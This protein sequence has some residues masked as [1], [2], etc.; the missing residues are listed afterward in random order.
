MCR[1]F[2]DITREQLIERAEHLKKT[3]RHGWRGQ[4]HK[5][6]YV[7]ELKVELQRIAHKIACMDCYKAYTTLDVPMWPKH[8]AVPVIFS[9][10]K[11]LTGQQ[12]EQRIEKL[13]GLKAPGMVKPCTKS[14][15]ANVSAQ[16]EY[17]HPRKDT[18]S[19]IRRREKQLRETA[20]SK[21]RE[22]EE[23][24]KRCKRLLAEHQEKIWSPV[25]AIVQEAILRSSYW[26]QITP[27]KF[28]DNYW[29]TFS[30]RVDSAGGLRSFYLTESNDGLSLLDIMGRVLV[31]SRTTKDIVSYVSQLLA[32]ADKHRN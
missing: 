7:Y 3:I 14:T 22:Y 11:Y 24:E 25:T 32:Y 1:K 12:R 17:K 15:K 19:E 18:L 16:E 4:K 2:K 31:M 9:T 27:I 29:P 23:N 13:K 8:K 20:E 30:V 21:Q 5:A 6:I 10:N 28:S 26:G